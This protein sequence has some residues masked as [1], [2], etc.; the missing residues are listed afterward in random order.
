MVPG[1]DPS[2]APLRVLGGFNI[3]GTSTDEA[4][5]IVGAGAATDIVGLWGF[6][7]CSLERITLD[8]DPAEFP[9]GETVVNRSG[10]QCLESG[11]LRVLTGT[12][13]GSNIDVTLTTYDLVGSTLVFRI[14][15]AGV[16]PDGDDLLEPYSRFECGSLTLSEPG[17]MPM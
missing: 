17:G 7:S 12:R 2:V 6:D 5:A 16:F 3:G 13:N 9:I 15:H 1:I 11:A 14:T 4:L 10:L 8:G